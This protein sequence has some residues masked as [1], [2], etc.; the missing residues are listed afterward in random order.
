MKKAVGLRYDGNS[1]A[2]QVVAR[3]GGMTAERIIQLAA[4]YNIPIVEEREAVQSLFLLNIGDCI[5]EDLYEI[6]AQILV[7][8]YGLQEEK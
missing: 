8:I 1:E 3:G 7:F 2:P 6:I 4:K 5:P